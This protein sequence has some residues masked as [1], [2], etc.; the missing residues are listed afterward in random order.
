VAGL[1]VTGCVLAAIFPSRALVLASVA[2]EAPAKVAAKV[3]A[4]AGV[5]TTT[6][7]LTPA[8]TRSVTV[9]RVGPMSADRGVRLIH[10]SQA[11]AE[12]QVTVIKHT[13]AGEAASWFKR[14]IGR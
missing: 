4:G 1:V 11:V 9:I 14:L 7:R 2:A 8:H 3:V 10:Q 6:Y 5:P 13:L 12:K